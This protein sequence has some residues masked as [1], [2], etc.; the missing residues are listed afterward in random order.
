MGNYKTIIGLDLSIRSSGVCIHKES[1]HETFTINPPDYLSTSARIE[2]IRIEIAEAISKHEP[3]MVAIEEL[4]FCRNAKVALKLAKLHGA[5]DNH[6]ERIKQ[7]TMQIEN[8]KLK[9]F[10]T[11]NGNASKEDMINNCNLK[12]GTSFIWKGKNSKF[13]QDDECDAFAL[14]KYAIANLLA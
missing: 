14:C 13:T 11:G 12:Y 1:G 8:R 6:L 5:I 3:E 10:I 7:P 2:L 9:Q 4:Y